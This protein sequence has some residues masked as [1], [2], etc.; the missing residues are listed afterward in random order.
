MND[1]K[2]TKIKNKLVFGGII[3]SVLCLLVFLVLDSLGVFSTKVMKKEEG[4]NLDI[5]GSAKQDIGDKRQLKKI[6]SGGGGED[7]SLEA[8]DKQ[9][10]DTL[11]PKDTITK[12]REQLQPNFRAKKSEAIR[13]AIAQRKREDSIA[14]ATPNVVGLS[15]DDLDIST[16]PISQ[17]KNS[18]VS[19]KGV[20]RKKKGKRKLTKAE[21]IQKQL[22]GYYDGGVS[23]SGADKGTNQKQKGLAGVEIPVYISST[24]KVVQGDRITLRF[25]EDMVLKG[26]RIKADDFFYGFVTFG[27]HRILITPAFPKK[28]RFLK[29]L[30]LYDATDDQQGIFV[31]GRDLAAE[32]KRFAQVQMI[33]D[34]KIEVN[35][36]SLTGALLDGAKALATRKVETPSIIVQSGTEIILK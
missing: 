8:F 10:N 26:R 17:T 12:I 32:Y 23:D 30:E 21:Q 2:K 5:V 28:Y 4:E 27:N 7:V 36:G 31:R 13:V 15:D 16:T 24:L 35:S 14:L 34:K 19:H 6:V 20:Q 18:R 11:K 25:S 33:N 22:D 1:I 9:V 3:F 29:G